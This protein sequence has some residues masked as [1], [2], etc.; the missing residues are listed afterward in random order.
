MKSNTRRTKAATAVVAGILIAL[1]N[2]VA[3][4]AEASVP[5]PNNTVLT[6][7][8]PDRYTFRTTTG[9]WS[10]VAMFPQK[11]SDYDLT[12]NAPAPYGTSRSARGQ[13][14]TDFLAIDS[15]SGRVPLSGYT[16]K[17]DHYVGTGSYAIELRQ[18]SII[19]TLP[20]PKWDG[21]SGASD[22]DLAFASLPYQHVA[23]IA[24]VYLNAGEKFWASS[25]GAANYLFLLESTSDTA[26]WIQSRDE[27]TGSGNTQVVDDCTLYTAKVSGWHGLLIVGDWT[28]SNPS[29]GGGTG[30]ALH[31]FNPAKP[32]TCPHKNFPGP[33]PA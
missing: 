6:S 26:T 8:N 21:V 18:G 1:I 31:R 10:V 3:A 23:A 30:Y 19:T 15:N 2:P 20:Q 33:T 24:D 27:A 4:A 11:G 9:Y 16:A 5:L 22:P 14:K 13:G 7:S 12:L 17:V 25:P 29:P 28:P 32:T